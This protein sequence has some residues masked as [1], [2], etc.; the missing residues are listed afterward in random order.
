MPLRARDLLPPEKFKCDLCGARYTEGSFV[1]IR[2]RYYNLCPNCAAAQ[3]R[4]IA[5]AREDAPV[6][7]R[8]VLLLAG[9][10]VLAVALVVW[11]IVWGW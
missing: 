1:S 9:A 5:A 2:G 8:T 4:K 6:D 7:R 3:R 10:L 11:S